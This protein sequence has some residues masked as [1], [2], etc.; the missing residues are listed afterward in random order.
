MN[1]K[2]LLILVILFF[3]PVASFAQQKEQPK[4]EMEKNDKTVDVKVDGKLFTQ[5]HFKGF[6]KP[7]FYPL[8]I[9][10]ST[11]LTRNYPIKKVE[12][13]QPDHPHH[14]SV[15]FSHQF[16]NIMFWAEHG[17]VEFTGF[18]KFSPDANPPTFSATHHWTHKGKVQ[19]TD[20]TTVAF[21]AEKN[22]RAINFTIT[23]HASHGDV[24]INDTKEGTFAVRVHPA[25][26]N[27]ANKKHKIPGG[28][29]MTNSEGESGRKIWGKAAAWV[30]YSG[31]IKD[32]FYGVAI[33]DHPDNIRH[34]TTWHARDYGLLAAN[35]FGQHYFQKKKKGAGEYTIKSGKSLT[36]RYRLVI[37]EGDAKT[38]KI[39]KLYEEFAKKRNDSSKK[40]GNQ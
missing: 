30:D 17:T 36:L 10:E 31:K 38:A 29:S 32:Q 15:W 39:D 5:Y 8:K 14:K 24:L 37:H 3:L 11:G 20:E 4:I 19:L 6:K 18:S 33:F 26:R 1:S 12:N 22:W 27:L 21:V 7:I 25:L 35:P 2:E 9:N 13:E 28:A 34:P 40:Q 16:N 23:L